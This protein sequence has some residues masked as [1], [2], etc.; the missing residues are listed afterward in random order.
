MTD[1][2]FQKFMIDHI[3][4]L[5]DDFTDF[6]QNVARMEFELSEK[7]NILFDG[8]EAIK[9]ILAD[10]T[11]RLQR[12]ENKTEKHDIQIRVLDETKSNKR[13]VK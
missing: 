6:R 4:K 3:T 5:S 1:K 11:E 10:H 9:D 7:I 8:Q 12:I 2:E 13:K